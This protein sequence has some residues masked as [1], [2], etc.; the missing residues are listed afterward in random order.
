MKTFALINEQT[1]TIENVVL[2]DGETPYESDGYKIV[3]IDVANAGIGW[4]YENDTFIEPPAP[5]EPE[6]IAV[7]AEAPNVIAE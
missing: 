3:E 1:N 4:T 5:P 2:W 6:I 7:I